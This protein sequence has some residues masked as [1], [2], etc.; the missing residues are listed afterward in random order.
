MAFL[1]PYFVRASAKSEF[2]CKALSDDKQARSVAKRLGLKV[3]GTIGMFIRAKQYG[4]IDLLKPVLDDLECNGFRMS[5]GL[6]AEA[7]KIVGE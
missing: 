6:K 2:L 4:L 3:I 7:L 5:E 1:R